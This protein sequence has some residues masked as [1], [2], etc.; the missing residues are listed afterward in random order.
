M[1]FAFALTFAFVAGCYFAL[2][3]LAWGDGAGNQWLGVF[4]CAFFVGAAL[5]ISIGSVA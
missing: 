3:L 1:G 4:G 2:A 5:F